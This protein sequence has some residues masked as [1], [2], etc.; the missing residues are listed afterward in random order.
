VKQ[1]A[2]TKLDVERSLPVASAL[3]HRNEW[4]SARNALE[5]GYMNDPYRAFVVSQRHHPTIALAN[6]FERF[7]QRQ[8]APS[9]GNTELISGMQLAY[10]L[11]HSSARLSPN[12]KSKLAQKIRG[13]FTDNVGIKPIYFELSIAHELSQRGW[14]VGYEDLEGR[15]QFDFLI[16]RREIEAE[17][18]CKYVRG[19]TGFN[20]K[21]NDFMNLA[22]LVR[23][24]LKKY[25]NHNLGLLVDITLAGKLGT[26]REEHDEINIQI[27]Q[28]TERAFAQGRGLVAANPSIKINVIF[29]NPTQSIEAIVKNSS[30]FEAITS[31][32]V[33]QLAGV[34]AEQAVADL[35]PK[36]HMT[37]ISCR[38]QLP[39]M[40]LASIG[41][42]MLEDS[43]KQ[44][45]KN[46]PALLLMQ[47]A[48]ISQRNIE[49]FGDQ[50]DVPLG[51]VREIDV[52]MKDF[53]ERR[54]FVHTVGLF[55]KEEV[56][57][58]T[59]G[60]TTG[61]HMFTYPNKSHP[62]ADQRDLTFRD[63]D[64]WR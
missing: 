54:P 21:E 15:A 26:T 44:L 16:R 33:G 14:R 56:R 8:S 41:D 57:P 40:L 47:F 13:S 34:P 1:T 9:I 4:I 19:D 64:N 37:I 43:K 23:A 60:Y 36:G 27:E 58:I 48:N 52:M 6:L 24:A 31:D 59:N 42:R 12:G 50:S 29:F 32:L 7:R 25:E 35:R 63:M 28:A 2:L 17:V 51:H 18:E 39:G 53:F 55:S 45:T 46:R 62:Q 30:L 61:G 10:M 49:A 3:V 20:I 22:K 5:K 38:S 11:A